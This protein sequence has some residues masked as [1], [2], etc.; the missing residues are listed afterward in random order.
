MKSLLVTCLIP[1]E[2]DMAL[3]LKE[4][5]EKMGNAEWNFGGN[6][7]RL[8]LIIHRAASA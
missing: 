4:R 1:A 3:N 8:G 5:T 7:M 6:S 2:R